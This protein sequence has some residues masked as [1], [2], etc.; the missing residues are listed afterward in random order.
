MSHVYSFI[1]HDAIIIILLYLP[2]L[3]LSITFPGKLNIHL[4]STMELLLGLAKEFII[5]PALHIM[6]TF[7]TLYG[8]NLAN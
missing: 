4:A 8:Q 3:A 5:C 6:K 1:A 7:N 2:F